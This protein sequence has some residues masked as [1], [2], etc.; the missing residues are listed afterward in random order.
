MHTAALQGIREKIARMKGR[1]DMEG[2]M[3]RISHLQ[4]QLE[5]EDLWVRDMKKATLLSKE[6][7]SLQSQTKTLIDLEDRVNALCDEVDLYIE[8]RE[9]EL[10]EGLSEEIT[11]VEKATRQLEMESLLGK[12]ED[13]KR[14]VYIDIH[15]GA[16]GNDSCEWVSML[17]RM[18]EKYSENKGFQVTTISHVDNLAGGFTS[19]ILKVHRIVLFVVF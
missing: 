17:K 12:D 13:D 9:E 8:E 15:A 1:D 7:G 19:I 2:N 16:G 4:G 10:L 18:Y 5:N 11:R 3:K 6:L 14:S